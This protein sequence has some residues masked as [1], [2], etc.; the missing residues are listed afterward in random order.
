M[1]TIRS[2]GVVSNKPRNYT[3]F[4]MLMRLMKEYGESGDIQKR[5]NE[6]KGREIEE[7]QKEVHPR[8]L[9]SGRTKDLRSDNLLYRFGKSAPEKEKKR[10]FKL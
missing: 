7:G 10:P 6:N 1:M 4:D 3:I 8:P 5:N 2:L 9:G